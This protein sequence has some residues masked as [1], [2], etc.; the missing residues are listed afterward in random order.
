MGKDPTTVLESA[1]L[2]AFALTRGI[3]PR[4]VL[5]E[6][7]NK[8]VFAFDKD[9]SS[10]IAEF[11]SNPPVLVADFCKNLKLVRSMIFA[12]KAGGIR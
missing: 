7:D 1:D 11:Y 9:I 3:Q 8:V 2:T 5:R 4:P 12:L 6:S 10:C